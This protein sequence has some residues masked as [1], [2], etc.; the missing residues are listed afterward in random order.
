MGI[1]TDILLCP[2][3][4]MILILLTPRKS[5]KAIKIIS[6]IVSGLSV[7]LSFIAYNR[8][9][10]RNVL[11]QMEERISWLPQYGINYWN[12][13]DGLNISMILLTSIVI[14]TGV[15]ISWK[16]SYRVKEFF[17]LLLF[18]VI[19]VFGVFMTLN[20]F[21]FFLF[22]EVA[23]LPMYLL[24]AI[25][26]STN[27]EYAALKLTLYLLL[28]SAFMFAIF[29]AIYSLAGAHTFDLLTIKKQVTFDP[30]FQKV[31][32]IGL[33]LGC[34]VLAGCWPFHVWSPDGHVAAPTAVSMLHAG[35]LMKLGAYGII[36]VAL[37]L[38]P[39]AAHTWAPFTVTLATFNI[40][41]G[42]L[43]ATQQKDLKYVI[44]YS[45]VSHMGIV[46]LGISTLTVTGL[47]GAL[48]QMFSH[49]IMTALFFACVG[50]VYDECHTR[51]FDELGGLAHKIPILSTFFIIAGLTGLGLPGLS[52]FPS[53]L[54]V[55]IAAIKTYPVSGIC[56]AIGVVVTTFY[57]VSAIMKAFYGPLN[58]HFEH[59]K[60]INLWQYFGRS[61]LV[62]FLLLL[63]VWPKLFLDIVNPITTY[64]LMKPF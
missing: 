23:V 64:L 14:F 43:V 61:I 41:Y 8:F 52:G 31:A 20:L 36:R 57:I 21:F 54:L 51:Y 26:G 19:G 29:L 50:H 62:A 7:I 6:L 22:Y 39:E 25:W 44:G 9:D 13:V 3:I 16:L 53:E 2:V 10:P 49:G 15:I 18:L 45:S 12:G 63:G 46:L 58:K 56:T 35:V 24:I 37:F 38:F 1:L 55:L 60:D 33:F 27:K 34:G 5:E 40:L 32:Y 28:G 11:L 17:A 59:I 48:F 30:A 42:A 47:N 4:G